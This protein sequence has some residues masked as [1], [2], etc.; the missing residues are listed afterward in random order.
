MLG[1]YGYKG[2]VMIS[3]IGLGIYW[4]HPW[5]TTTHPARTLH[6]ELK[7]CMSECK[8]RT[9]LMVRMLWQL[10][11]AIPTANFMLAPGWRKTVPCM[12][13]ADRRH[14]C[15]S[16][17]SFVSRWQ[18]WLVTTWTEVVVSPPCLTRPGRWDMTDSSCGG[19]GAS[20]LQSWT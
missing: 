4:P 19:F 12:R 5:L 18:L 15:W 13:S 14:I 2:E 20:A 8:V 11:T 3:P 10:V 7:D 17:S 9:D 1:T 16:G 6:N